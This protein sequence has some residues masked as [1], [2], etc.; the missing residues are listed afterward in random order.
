MDPLDGRVLAKLLAAWR[1]ARRRTSGTVAGTAERR[2]AERS[3]RIARWA[4]EDESLRRHAAH[5]LAESLRRRIRRVG[6]R[7]RQVV[8]ASTEARDATAAAQDDI[9][10][11]R[12][13]E[14][15]G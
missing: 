13:L 5:G 2:A 9:E 3:E 12:E 4:Y 7:S 6:N 10:I 1:R 11:R 8:R 15:S 14:E